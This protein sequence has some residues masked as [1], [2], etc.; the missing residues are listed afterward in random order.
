M[1]PNNKP[2]PGNK[3]LI[4]G[5]CKVSFPVLWSEKSAIVCWHYFNTGWLQ[6]SPVIRTMQQATMFY[7]QQLG[8]PACDLDS[9]FSCGPFELVHEQK[10]AA[11]S[12]IFPGEMGAKWSHRETWDHGTCGCFLAVTLPKSSRM[13][14]ERQNNLETACHTQS[15]SMFTY[16]SGVI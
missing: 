5:Y 7:Y 3:A 13:Q 1:P 12:W 2:C 8:T 10:T 11:F 14:I 6:H 16:T 9:A 4:R 15:R